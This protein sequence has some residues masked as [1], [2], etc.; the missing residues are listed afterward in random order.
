MAIPGETFDIVESELR[1]GW[2]NK[3]MGRYEKTIR[4]IPIKQF[5]RD[6]IIISISTLVSNVANENPRNQKGINHFQPDPVLVAALCDYWT[7]QF[8]NLEDL[9]LELAPTI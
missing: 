8:E 5:Q 6:R 1:P 9:I 3:L 2:W 7:E 4:Q